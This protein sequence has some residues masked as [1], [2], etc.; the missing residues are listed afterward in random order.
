M[1]L[2]VCLAT[3]L[4]PDVQPLMPRGRGRILQRERMNLEVFSRLFDPSKSGPVMS[5]NEVD[6]AE[7]ILAAEDAAD[8]D[9]RVDE[10]V[11]SGAAMAALRD[12]L[13]RAP[14][15]TLIQAADKLEAM[16]HDPGA[17]RKL[18]HLLT[19]NAR[20]LLSLSATAV[21]AISPNEPADWSEDFAKMDVTQLVFDLTVPAFVRQAAY[22]YLR[23]VACSIALAR[24]MDEGEPHARRI[25]LAIVN[26]A[27][28]SLYEEL[29]L[30]STQQSESELEQAERAKR[31]FERLSHSGEKFEVTVPK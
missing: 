2:F 21:R 6:V 4:N 1:G 23:H 8:L 10:A 25:T 3:C 17:L 30:L 13:T 7:A 31:L 20:A 28:L 14:Q 16:M 9:E 11:T 26:M 29:R 18:D 12:A 19:P 24:I 22:E 5:K 15:L 27:T